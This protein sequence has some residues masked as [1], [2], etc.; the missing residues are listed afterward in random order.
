MT[1]DN[2]KNNK[3][4]ILIVEDSDVIA[5]LLEAIFSSQD[6]MEVIGR[7]KNGAEGVIMAEKLK[8]TLIT[9]DIRMPKKDGFE[10]TKM[11]METNPTPIIVIS[12]SVDSIE[13]QIAFNALAAGALTVIEKPENVSFD[14]FTEVEKEL[15]TTIRAL[16]SIRVIRR[17]RPKKSGSEDLQPSSTPRKNRECRLLALGVSTGGPEALSYIL[18]NLPQHLSVPVVIVQHMAK[19][20]IPGLVG[21]ISRMTPL[22]VKLAEDGEALS[23]GVVYF[24]PDGAHLTVQSEGDRL[25]AVLVRAPAVDGFCPS[26]TELFSSVAHALPGRAMAG[27]LTG[28]GRDGAAGL[29]A[30]HHRNCL[31]FV[32]DQASSIV[33]GMP[34]EAL[35]LKAADDVVGLKDIP[36]YIIQNT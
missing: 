18:A 15:I 14:G 4:R 5:G 27:L 35:K 12:S 8:P 29:L 34:D 1:D 36:A 3:I 28:M 25:K 30:M 11:I 32:Q 7:A 22:E 17:R 2:N 6:D 33:F 26:V 24:A 16:S 13:L 31:T 23:S 10:A 20:F 21:W 19:G 9:M